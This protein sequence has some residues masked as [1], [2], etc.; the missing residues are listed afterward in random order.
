[1]VT[2]P[3]RRAN[4]ICEMTTEVASAEYGVIIYH[5]ERKTLE[6]KWLPTTKDATETAAKDTMAL[7]A[8]ETEKLKPQFLLISRHHRVLAPAGPMT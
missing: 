5:D 2:G 7:F 3:Y 6:L 8:A 4:L 1:L